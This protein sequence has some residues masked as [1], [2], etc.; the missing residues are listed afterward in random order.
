MHDVTEMLNNAHLQWDL[1]SLGLMH[2]TM[3]T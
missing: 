2:Y 3:D 1:G